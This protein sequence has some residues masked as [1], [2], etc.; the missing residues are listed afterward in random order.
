MQ[1][2][3]KKQIVSHL[4]AYS[5]EHVAPLYFEG[6]LKGRYTRDPDAASMIDLL[7]NSITTD[8]GIAWGNS[9]K[10]IPHAFRDC[11]VLNAGTIGRRATEWQTALNELTEKLVM[12]VNGGAED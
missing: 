5:S 6:A 2:R 9:I 11:E 8:F 3:A 7:H 10:N 1:N 12:Y 4:C